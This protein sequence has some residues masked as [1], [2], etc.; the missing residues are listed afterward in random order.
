M[1]KN[2]HRQALLYSTVA[3]AFVAWIASMLRGEITDARI[4]ET[5]Y[6][7]IMIGMTQADVEQIFARP[8]GEYHVPGDVS[9]VLAYYPPSPGLGGFAMYRKPIRDVIWRGDDGVVR[10]IFDESGRVWRKYA[11]WAR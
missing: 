7:R 11:S 1:T 10:V 9:N 6:R 5:N 2:Q 4:S 8:P 3:L